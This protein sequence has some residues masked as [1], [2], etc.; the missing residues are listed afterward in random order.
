MVK[1][2]TNWIFRTVTTVKIAE[3]H[4]T[5]VKAVSTSGLNLIPSP[6]CDT[7]WILLHIS[8]NGKNKYLGRNNK[9]G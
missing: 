7:Y 8:M 3:C 9:T 6:L 2:R 1:S 4:V 5:P